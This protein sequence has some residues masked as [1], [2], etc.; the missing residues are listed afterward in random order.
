MLDVFLDSK[1]DLGRFAS[2]INPIDQREVTAAA[3]SWHYNSENRR[4]IKN[5]TSD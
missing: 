4:H 3:N 2:G 1:V 5:N